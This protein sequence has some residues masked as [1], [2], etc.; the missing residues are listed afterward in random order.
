[1]S[2]C[3]IPVLTPRAKR[4]STEIQLKFNWNSAPWRAG[5]GDGRGARLI[6]FSLK[7]QWSKR[8][9]AF[10]AAGG[11]RYKVVNCE[12]IFGNFFFKKCEKMKFFQ[13]KIENLT[14]Q[15]NWSRGP[16]EKWSKY[17]NHRAGYF[18]LF[19]SRNGNRED[20]VKTDGSNTPSRLQFWGCQKMNRN[21]PRGTKSPERTQHTPHTP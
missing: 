16:V 8:F 3:Y 18:A 11:A 5:V 13:W 4:D 19:P 2:P 14:T 6:T 7:E 9:F 12:S 20:S 21:R 15:L 1:M 10:F 17:K